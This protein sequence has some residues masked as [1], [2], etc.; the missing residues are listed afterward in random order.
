MR[1][2][3]IKARVASI[4]TVV[5]KLEQ[6]GIVVSEPVRQRDEVFGIPGVA[7]DS[8]NS[9]PW[10][11]IRTET[12]NS[13]TKYVYTL[14][15]SVTNQLDSIEHE[16]V[17]EDADE[18]RQIILHSG[19]VPFSEV[20]K[21]RRKAKIGDIEI[22]IDTVEK[23][24]DFVEAEKL[25]GEDADYEAVAMELWELLEQYGANRSDEVTDGYDTMMEH[26]N[27]HSGLQ[28]KQ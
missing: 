26:L 15:K 16:T 23:L 27:A 14:K 18:L 17:V 25:T 20:T 12:K 8:A 6:A 1:E 22:C 3:E 21:T 11:R 13:N 5:E 19:F 10:L 2:I 24:G 4:A 9:E 28:A 7:G